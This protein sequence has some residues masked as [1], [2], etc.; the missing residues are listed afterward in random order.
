MLQ[1]LIAAIIVV[2]AAVWLLMNAYAKLNSSQ[3]R[4][5]ACG[6]GC[7]GCSVSNTDKT[8]CNGVVQIQ[9]PIDK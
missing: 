6:G 3:N 8:G 7:S 4:Q 5:S 2:L 9:N 1:T